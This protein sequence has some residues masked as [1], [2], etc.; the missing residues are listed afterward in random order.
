MSVPSNI[1]EGHARGSDK[2][3]AH[4][5]AIALGSLAE[6]E[7]QLVIAERLAYLDSGTVETLLAKLDTLGKMVRGLKKAASS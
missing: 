2:E 6:V 4:Y 1:A 5:L 7:T 3:L